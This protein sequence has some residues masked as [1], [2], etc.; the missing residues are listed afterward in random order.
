MPTYDYA[1]NACGHAL[2][3]FHSMAEAPRK[4]C[5]R[6]GKNQLERRIGAGA[7]FLF[8]G[9]GFYQTDYRSESYSKAAKAESEGA[10]KPAAEKAES[11]GD[12]KPA[13]KEPSAKPAAE[14]PKK[15]GKD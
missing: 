10:T 14:Q 13:A 7:G 6:C 12:A 4:K 15:K 3:L 2:E 9:S 5:P 8:K 11:G 1:C